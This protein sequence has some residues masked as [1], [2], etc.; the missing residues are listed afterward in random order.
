MPFGEKI[1]SKAKQ[2]RREVVALWFAA[3]D[4]LTPWYAKVIALLVTAYAL[5]PIDLIPDFIPL[6]G[7]LDDLVLIPAGIAL[8]I[9]LIPP[10]VM[11]SCREKADLEAKKPVSIVG[12]III[13]LVWLTIL[14]LIGRALYPLILS[15]H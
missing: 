8:S 11:Q 4:P 12:G 3:R 9:K 2:L 15:K 13:V 6:L 1:K 10:E 5:S 14:F 7:Y